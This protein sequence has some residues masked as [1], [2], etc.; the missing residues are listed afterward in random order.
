MVALRVAMPLAWKI[1]LLAVVVPMAISAFS[2]GQTPEPGVS[3]APFPDLVKLR[4]G[5]FRYRAAGEFTR[6]G[7]P[8]TAPIVTTTIKS[9]LSVTRH[10][11]TAAD[12]RRCVE[13]EVCPM[14]D[15]DAVAP[16]RP[17][18][19]VS[20]RD[21]HAYA[22]WLSRATGL[23]FRLPSDEEWAYAAADRFYDDA[24][25]EISDVS[26]PGQRAL[27]IYDRDAS[28]E[29][30]VDKAPQL[31]GSFGANE[32]G[33]LDVAGNVWEWTATCFVRSTLNARGEVAATMSNCGVRVVEGRHRTYITDFIR[34]AR[35]GGCSVGTAPSNLGFRLVR[36]DDPL[37]KPIP[38]VKPA[39]LF[40]RGP[41]LTSLR[42]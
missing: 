4:P 40:V 10:Q 9:T 23:H 19:N 42:E 29:E 2:S 6:D 1:R 7:K 16:D 30:V 5:T 20:W 27:A 34:D 21:A 12:Y 14:V 33:L 15:R 36:D 18:V 11:V 8:V 35:A 38:V 31:I 32:N 22:F 13:A 39:L 37:S 3:R 17:A 28:R 41:R 26:D 25:S 24:L